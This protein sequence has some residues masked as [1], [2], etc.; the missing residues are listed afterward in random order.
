M[1]N[2][3]GTVPLS[4]SAYEQEIVSIVD[5]TR[6]SAQVQ[7]TVIIASYR[8]E[9]MLLACLDA[10]V[11]QQ[12]ADDA[13]EI[14]LVD[15]GGNEEVHDR[16]LEYPIRHLRLRRNL[17]CSPGKNIGALVAKGEIV[18]F[19]DDDALADPGFVSAHVRA[20]QELPEIVGVRGKVLP[21]SPPNIYNGLAWHYDLGN[22]VIP[23]YIDTETNA[24]FRRQA[25]LAASGFTSPVQRGDMEGVALSYRLARLC[26]DP[27]VLVYYP[28]AVIYHD[29]AASLSKLTRKSRAHVQ[30][31]RALSAEIG[32]SDVSLQDFIHSYHLPP[33]TIHTPRDAWSRLRLKMVREYLEFLTL[34]QRFL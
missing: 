28:A 30:A 21:K 14:I 31:R 19:I 20:Y 22:A 18:C 2:P 25:F 10:L 3:A 1:I 26:G 15:N 32:C 12:F 5:N 13:W 4:I 9:R 7:A 29:Y 11:R 6:R 34:F 17:G 33:G 8:A 27:A 24:S 23:A 16:L